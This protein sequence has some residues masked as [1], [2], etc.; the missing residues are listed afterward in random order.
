MKQF[1]LPPAY[2]G[3][4]TLTLSGGDFHYLHRVRRMQVGD[5]IPGRSR[6]GRA[7]RLTVV[8]VGDK[9]MQ[10]RVDAD[11][12]AENDG[13]FGGGGV[14]EPDIT[15]FQCL[16][17]GKKL[18]QI[19]R[20]ATE[21]GVHR[22]IPVKSWRAVS[23]LDDPARAQKRLARLRRI[24]EEAVQQSGREHVPRVDEVRSLTEVPPVDPHDGDQEGF[25][26][27]EKAIAAPKIGGYLSAGPRRVALVVGPEGGLTEQEV[28]SLGR[29]GFNPVSLGPQVLRTETAAVYAIAAIQSVYRELVSWKQAQPSS[30]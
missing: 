22:I 8:S 21:A 1:V 24:A 30:R 7:Y 3:E 13:A 11:G 19:V 10:L 15:L 29:R 12:A 16:P 9:S 27:H 2:A 26:F 17:K 20:Q 25:V 28:S 4:T 6:D 18:D 5:S 23:R 14:E